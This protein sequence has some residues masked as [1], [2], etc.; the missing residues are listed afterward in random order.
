MKY[1]K[2]SVLFLFFIV[3]SIFGIDLP[4]GFTEKVIAV[5]DNPTTMAQ[6]PDGRI[7][8][9]TQNGQIFIYKNNILLSKPFISLHVNSE[10]ERGLIGIAFDPDFKKNQFLYL[11]Y[12]VPVAPIHNRVSRFTANDD[13]VKSGS[14]K[15][16]FEIINAAAAPNHHSGA[17]AFGEDGK[18]YIAVGENAKPSNS[19]SLENLLGKILRINADGS[20]PNDNPFYK[21]AI[22][23]NRAIY[24]LGLRNPF[25]FSIQPGS[26]KI[27]VNDDGQES[28]EEI[29]YIKPGGNYGWPNAEGNSNDKKFIN[30]IFTYHH[31]NGEIKGCSVIGS[32]FYNPASRQFPL[33]YFGKYF[34]GD[35]CSGFIKI[36]DPETG[37]VEGFAKG[38]NSLVNI[39]TGI[40]GSLY[41]LER[42]DGGKLHKISYKLP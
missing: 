22:G 29:N 37:K 28:W 8:I 20:I 38:L 14:E 5:I 10:G 2:I 9:L 16:I 27:F 3:H 39:L 31:I 33:H 11:H 36:M 18:L 13:L 25:T 19:Q 34:F 4:A 24:A 7:F 17:M 26:G 6:A 35:Y 42:G 23:E 12:T 21:A 41:Y 1:L 15:I 40:D 30:P 32:S